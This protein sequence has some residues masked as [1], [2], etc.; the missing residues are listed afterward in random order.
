MGD[1]YTLYLSAD[2]ITSKILKNGEP[3][4]DV[5]RVSVYVDVMEGAMI[6]ITHANV[7]VNVFPEE[8]VE[9]EHEVE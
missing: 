8:D 1:K 6:T 7:D 9:V 4:L 3:M 2:G 5:V